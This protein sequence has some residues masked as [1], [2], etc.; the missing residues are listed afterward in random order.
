MWYSCGL[1]I[2]VAN[3]TKLKSGAAAIEN[4]LRLD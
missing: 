4:L 3:I 1:N 2:R